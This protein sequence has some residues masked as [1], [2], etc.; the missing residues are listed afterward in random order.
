MLYVLLAGKQ[1]CAPSP[2]ALRLAFSKKK[3]K[4][5]EKKKKKSFTIALNDKS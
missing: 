5:K 1:N 4:K 2:A 3:K